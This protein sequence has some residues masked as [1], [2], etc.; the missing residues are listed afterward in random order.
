MWVQS[1]GWG[2]SLEKGMTTHP[3]ILAWRIPWTEK[4]GKLQSQGC[5]ESDTTE[6][7]QHTCTWF[8]ACQASLSMGFSRQEHWSGLGFLLQGI[9]PT[10]GQ[11]SHLICLLYWQEGSLPLVLPGKPILNNK[12]L[13]FLIIKLIRNIV[14]FLYILNQYDSSG[15]RTLLN[16]CKYTHTLYQFPRAAIEI[17]EIP[18]SCG[19]SSRT[20]FSC[21]FRSQKS[22]DQSVDWF[23]FS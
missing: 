13:L 3:S 11:N 23:G 5:K 10:Q 4:S 15:N 21:S 19:L 22:K 6:A 18:Q 16:I 12:K 20:L 1:Q 14:S 9:F 8:V 17:T 7:T 2:D